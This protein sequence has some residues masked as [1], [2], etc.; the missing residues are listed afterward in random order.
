MPIPRDAPIAWESQ[1]PG[2]A[3]ADNTG[4]IT[5]SNPG[6]VRITAT[7]SAEVLPPRTVTN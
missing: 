7:I 5:V 3:V 4:L 2:C 1:S 6:M